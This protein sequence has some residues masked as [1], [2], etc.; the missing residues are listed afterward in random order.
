MKEYCYIVAGHCFSVLTT[1]EV[2]LSEELAHYAPFAAEA[3]TAP[4]RVFRLQVVPAAA[5]PDP[6]SMTEEFT[7][8][9]DGSQIRLCRTADG[10]SWFEFSLWGSLAGKMR[11]EPGYRDSTLAICRHSGFALSNAL[12]VLYA[13]ATAEL[14]TALFHAAVIGHGGRGYLFLGKS[15]T[16]KSTHARLWLKHVPGSELVNDDNPVVRVFPDGTARVYGSP[17]SG[18]TP[19]YRNMDLPLGGFVQLE[20]AP[21]NAIRRLKSIS[22]YAAL[23]PSISGKRWDRRLADGLHETENALASHVPVWHLDC[24]PDEAA[25]LLC[26]QTITK[27]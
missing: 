19:C 3:G 4:E 11:S 20:Q 27:A 8:D 10:D 9:D 24:L 13:M 15:G 26:S 18:K 12:M 2:D 6:E 21:Y 22:A 5:L 14:G 25:A 17:W 23:V 1:G 7:Q 16:G